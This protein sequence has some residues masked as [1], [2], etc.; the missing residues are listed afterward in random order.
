MDAFK[1][2]SRK[3]YKQCQYLEWKKKEIY[4]QFRF[5]KDEINPRMYIFEAEKSMALLFFADEKEAIYFN[6]VVQKRIGDIANFHVIS[7][8]SK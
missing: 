1:K 8:Q 5:T 6:E 3:C 7:T 4:H 2:A